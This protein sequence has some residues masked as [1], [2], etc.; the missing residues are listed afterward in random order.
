MLQ[1]MQAL[2]PPPRDLDTVLRWDHSRRRRRLLYSQHRQDIIDAVRVAVGSEREQAWGAVDLSANPYLSLWEQA[3]R[4]YGARPVVVGGGAAEKACADAGLWS[5]MQR[6]QRD[7]L[8]LREMGL[9]VDAVDGR[10][11]FTPIFP[12][13]MEAEA[14]AAEP[15]QPVVLTETRWHGGRWVRVTWDARSAEHYATE[16]DGS[17][18]SDDVLGGR[19]DGDR[20]P[21]VLDGL[22][23]VPVVIYHASETSRLW[24]AWTGC[25]IVEGSLTLGVLLTYFGHAVKNAAWAQRYAVGVDVMGVGVEGSANGSRTQVVADPATVLML[26]AQ[27]NTQPQVGQ[28]DPPIDPMTLINAIRSYEERLVESAGLRLDV[29]R[30]NSDIRSGYSLAVARDAIR[31]SQASYAPV[32]ARADAR[33]IKIA[34]SLLEQPVDEVEV[35]YQGLPQSP[36]ERKAAI[37]E[38][39]ALRGAGLMSRSEAWMRLHPGSTEAEATAALAA[40]DREGTA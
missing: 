1:T 11:V 19:W 9:R 2:P 21:Y 39:I 22:P 18:A 33:T 26:A 29:T 25:E 14:S 13:L 40:I 12:D 7:T 36:A 35:L 4:L 38:V 17:D 34:G 15:S 8:G 3:S 24:D 31:E 32:F 20:Y 5:L 23:V 10:P 28:W 27:D 6:V 16:V 30:Q 37:D